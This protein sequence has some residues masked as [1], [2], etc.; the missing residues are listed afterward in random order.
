MTVGKCITGHFVTNICCR[1]PIKACVAWRGTGTQERLPRSLGIAAH[2][3]AGRS[4]IDEGQY[5]VQMTAFYSPHPE[6]EY[7]E[8]IRGCPSYGQRPTLSQLKDSE[9]HI[10]LC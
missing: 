1:I 4:F 6:D 5:H 9:S 7:G 3:I 8:I 10:I 2:Y